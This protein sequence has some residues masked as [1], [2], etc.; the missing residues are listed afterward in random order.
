MAVIREKIVLRKRRKEGERLPNRVRLDNVGGKDTLIV[1]IVVDRKNGI[2]HWY[3]FLPEQMA[4]RKAVIF[5]VS[6]GEVYWLSGAKPTRIYESDLPEEPQPEPVQIRRGRKPNVKIDTSSQTDPD[7]R[8]KPRKRKVLVFDSEQKLAL[9][10]A[11]LEAASDYIHILPESIKKLCKNKKASQDT[12]LFFRY[13]WKKPGPDI[14]IM[15]FSLTLARYDELC[16]RIPKG[17]GE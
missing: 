14:N 8:K 1:E 15:D 7:W 12:G 9:V 11:D 16:K 6:G 4:G 17:K 10:C 13:L 3:R 2:T 5:T